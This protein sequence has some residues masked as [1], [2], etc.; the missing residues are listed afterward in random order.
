M[1]NTVKAILKEEGSQHSQESHQDG[2]AQ[3]PSKFHER[4]E[5][6]VHD[7]WEMEVWSRWDLP[8]GNVHI[9]RNVIY[10]LA[11]YLG[12]FGAFQL[13]TDRHHIPGNDSVFVQVHL[14][15]DDNHVTLH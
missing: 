15:T 4:I 10:H 13:T 9:W 11:A 14:P 5:T 1:R 2:R 12:T 6:N 7:V 3:Y 8:V